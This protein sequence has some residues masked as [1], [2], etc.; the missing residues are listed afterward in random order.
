MLVGLI[1]ILIQGCISLGG[2]GAVWSICEQ[3]GRIDLARLA[4]N[5]LVQ[6]FP[7]L[8]LLE[9]HENK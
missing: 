4:H 6:R 5:T 7:I 2:I 3:G 9:D 1:A 8:L